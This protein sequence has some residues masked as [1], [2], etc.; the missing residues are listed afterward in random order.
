[1][2]WAGCRVWAACFGGQV[3][4]MAR[5]T[6]SMSFPVCDACCDMVGCVHVCMYVGIGRGL[7]CWGMGCILFLRSCVVPMCV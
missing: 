4:D 1:V 5:W 2:R 7:G 6:V 3:G